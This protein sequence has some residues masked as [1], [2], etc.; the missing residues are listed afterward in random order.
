MCEGMIG[1]V[2]LTVSQGG[3]LMASGL[4]GGKPFAKKESI[5]GPALAHSRVAHRAVY[6][7][8]VFGGVWN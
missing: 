5:R 6:G 3:N 4:S 1:Q 8:L 7:L 2:T